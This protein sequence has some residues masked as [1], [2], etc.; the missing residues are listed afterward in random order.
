MTSSGH[1][2]SLQVFT[3][4]QRAGSKEMN[5]G[6]DN[7]VKGYLPYTWACS[8]CPILINLFDIKIY[9]HIIKLFSQFFR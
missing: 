6:V 2:E 9:R 5:E 7:S 3:H 1:F 8:Y 4:P